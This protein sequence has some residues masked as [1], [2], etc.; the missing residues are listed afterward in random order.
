MY[1]NDKVTFQIIIREMKRRLEG[2]GIDLSFA[3]R[4][5][6]VSRALFDLTANEI[7]QKLSRNHRVPFQWDYNT[8]HQAWSIWTRIR[9]SMG[10]IELTDSQIM[11]LFVSVVASVIHRIEPSMR[12][13]ILQSRLGMQ[14]IP[15]FPLDHCVNPRGLGNSFYLRLDLWGNEL[16]SYARPIFYDGVYVPTSLLQAYPSID[17]ETYSL[18]RN[19]YDIAV[20]KATTMALLTPNDVSI[21]G[22][23]L[24]KIRD[25]H[26]LIQGLPGDET[27]LNTLVEQL[28][29]EVESQ[30]SSYKTLESINRGEA[31]NWIIDVDVRCDLR[32]NSVINQL[33]ICLPEPCGFEELVRELLYPSGLAIRSQDF[34]EFASQMGMHLRRIGRINDMELDDVSSCRSMSLDNSSTEEVVTL[35]QAIVQAYRDTIE[36]YRESV[37]CQLRLLTKKDCSDPIFELI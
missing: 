5:E 30:L 12:N 6:V 4:R 9:T 14:L 19:A 23:D 1:L 3:D 29:E 2:V 18:I 13:I 22:D 24:A 10:D 33:G 26:L 36:Q 35:P 15:F 34:Y 20:G 11:E 21:L 25:E 32:W 31:H 8:T 27:T 7:D 17:C 28:I 37:G 16:P